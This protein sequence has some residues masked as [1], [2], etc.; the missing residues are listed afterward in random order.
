[1]TFL[2]M[3]DATK[4]FFDDSGDGE[5]ILFAHGL[6]SFNFKTESS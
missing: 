4:I 6:N 3:S 1:M 2:K 5:A